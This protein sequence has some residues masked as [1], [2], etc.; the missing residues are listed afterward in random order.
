MQD[1]AGNLWGQ[2]LNVSAQ[3]PGPAAQ[4]GPVLVN[5]DLPVNEPGG[6]TVS[7]FPPLAPPSDD[8]Q[9]LVLLDYGQGGNATTFVQYTRR[10][11]SFNVPGSYVRVRCVVL[12]S[13]SAGTNYAVSAMA[14]I[15]QRQGL[16]S[17]SW[18]TIQPGIPVG[19]SADIDLTTNQSISMFAR[20]LNVQAFPAAPYRVEFYEFDPTGI[21]PGALLAR[22]EDAAGARKDGLIVPA[23]ALLMRLQNDGAVPIDVFYEFEFDL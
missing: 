22:Y 3:A 2:T 17:L 21:P 9:V 20:R 11:L 1:E 15:G 7:I 23:N 6:F 16:P 18:Q 4:S 19:G 14:T 12:S 5:V 13:V 8:L 10:P